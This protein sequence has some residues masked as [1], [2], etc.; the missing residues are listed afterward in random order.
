MRHLFNRRSAL[1]LVA[2]AAGA[3]AT[4]STETLLFAAVD[5]VPPIDDT[6]LSLT[7]RT[8]GP[9]GGGKCEPLTFGEMDR[10]FYALQTYINA[11]EARIKEL[12]AGR[13]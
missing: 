12:E 6:P 11:L 2:I 1:Q 4:V 3:G 9:W 7:Y 5:H 10:N 8:L 13:K